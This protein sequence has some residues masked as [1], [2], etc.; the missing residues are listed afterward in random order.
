MCSSDLLGHVTNRMFTTLESKGILRTAPEESMLA[1]LHKVSDPLAAEFV[2]T[3]RHEFFFG[4]QLLQRYEHL[5]EEAAQQKVSVL[6]PKFVG[7]RNKTDFASL[8]GFRPQHADTFFLSPWEFCQWF[9]AV[10]LQPPSASNALAKW[11][12]TGK[13]KFGTGDMQ[14]LRPIEDYE[15]DLSKMTV[16]NGSYRFPSAEVVFT[17]T[18]PDSY[19]RFRSLW[20]LQKRLIPKVPCPENTPLPNRRVSKETRAKIFSIY[21][22]PWT[23]AKRL[24]TDMV[25]FLS[26]LALLDETGTAQEEEIGRASCR[27]RV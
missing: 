20:C 7:G 19:I 17:G 16:T 8:Y 14:N 2:R 25:P 1:S 13:T 22:R 15:F 6:L 5:R 23:L 4:R 11:T 21:L 26:D 10:Q 18:A 3:F 9:E 12:S 27:E 24:A